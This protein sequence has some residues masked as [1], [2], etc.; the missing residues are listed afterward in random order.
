MSALSRKPMWQNKRSSFSKHKR[1]QFNYGDSLNGT[2]ILLNVPCGQ[3]EQQFMVECNTL[4][5][6]VKNY[7]NLGEYYQ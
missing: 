2:S 1:A 6:K 4:Y 7:V 5:K 3:E